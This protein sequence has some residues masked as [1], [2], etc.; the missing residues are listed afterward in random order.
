MIVKLSKPILIGDQELTELDLREPTIAEVS[1]LGY[2]FLVVESQGGSG[3]QALPKVV[4]A[5]ASK[6]AAVPP[7]SLKNIS[8]TDLLALQGAVQSFFGDMAETPAN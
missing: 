5:Y 6:L 7:S 2:P 8:I 4:L 3:I 1:E